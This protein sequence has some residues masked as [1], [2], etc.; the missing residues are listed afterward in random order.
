MIAPSITK[1]PKALTMTITVE[2]D[3]PVERAWQ[4][5]ADPRQLERWWGPPTYPATVK[6]HDLV[7]GGRVT[8]FMTG[9]GGDKANGWWE[10]LAVDPPKRLELKDGFA[11]DS[12]TPNY[13]MPITIMV[14][15]LTERA[16][17]G[18]VMATESRFPSL[19][20]MEQLVAMGMDE[21]ITL[22]MGQ[23]EGVLADDVRTQ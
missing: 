7:P 13:D 5:W 9:P 14:M 21:G 6:E 18:T 11:D 19:E 23:I 10:V 8:Y 16:G 12:G 1:D 2:L 3:V 15:T 22:A 17:G 4:L 20:A